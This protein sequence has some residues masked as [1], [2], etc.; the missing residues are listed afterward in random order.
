MIQHSTTNSS[1]IKVVAE[2]SFQANVVFVFVFVVGAGG[3]PQ[4]TGKP[5]KKP[6]K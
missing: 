4:E 6:S 3:K 5:V 2:I 1:M